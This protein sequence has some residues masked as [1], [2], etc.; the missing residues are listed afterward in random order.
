MDEV[1]NDLL[2]G[3]AGEK[4]D[5]RAL[6]P[7]EMSALLDSIPGAWEDVERGR[8]QAESGDTIP[9]EDL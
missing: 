6:P 2:A 8:R 3:S 4:R 7:A 9:L 1:E 5:L